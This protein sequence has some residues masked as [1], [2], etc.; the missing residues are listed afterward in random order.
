[1]EP[2]WANLKELNLNSVIASISW[3][4]FEP[5]EGIYDF[6][7]T[8]GIIAKAKSHNLKLCLIW[9]ASWKN[10]LSSYTPMWVRKDIKRF[11]RVQDKNGNNMDRISPC[12]EAA[13]F[14]DAKAYSVLM[15]H[16]KEIDND[17][18]VIIMQ[19]NNEVGI[20]QD[21]DYCR[22]SM[23]LFQSEVPVKLMEYLNRNRNSLNIELKTVWALNNYASKGSW[24]EIF[25][26]NPSA[27]FIM[28][29]L[30][31]RPGAA[32]TRSAGTAFP[33]HTTQA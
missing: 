22:E 3:E 20:K 30:M 29:V 12:C 8:D 5:K 18:T 13:K 32:T 27:T 15:K 23:K 7:L 6:T 25:G 17:Q 26:D 2:L 16:I 1:M 14:A 33:C 31:P 19:V 10:G 21:I 11:F 24:I 9:F 4:Q 28:L